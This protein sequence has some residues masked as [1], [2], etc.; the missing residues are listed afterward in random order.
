MPRVKTRPL[1]GRGDPPPV[2]V[3][4][5]E[6]GMP[7]VLI[8]DHAG[9][10]I[11]RSLGTLGLSPAEL[12]RHIAYD[13]GAEGVTRLLA[14]RLDAPAVLAPYSRLV[15]DCNRAPGHPESIIA[16][17]DG[18]PIPG[19]QNLSVEAAEAR[20]DSVFWAYHRAVS[21]TI[22]RHWRRL[23]I[24]PGVFSVHTFTPRFKGQDRPWDAGVLWNR[25]SR[26]A[27]PLMDM[28]ASLDGFK[29][30]DNLPYSGLQSAY[31]IDIHGAAAGLPNCVIEVRQDQVDTPAGIAMWAARLADI[32]AKIFAAETI[33]RVQRF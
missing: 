2:E 14:E 9:R 6:G 32:L 3:L 1:L 18:T 16:M 12:G 33:H 21:T 29:V 7:L 27:T 23:G 13:I 24:P 19:N 17:S 30:G 31:T 10:A 4:N 22:A 8:C 11:P 28:L 15:I 26:I 5:P 25:D 20:I